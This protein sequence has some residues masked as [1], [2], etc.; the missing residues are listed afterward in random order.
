MVE[1]TDRDVVF[2]DDAVTKYGDDESSRRPSDHNTAVTKTN[3]KKESKFQHKWALIYCTYAV[4]G[5]LLYGYDGTY[6]TGVQAMTAFLQR[7]GQLQADGSYALSA[8]NLSI[9]TSIVYVGELIG[10]M[11]ASLV[12]DRFG[13]KGGLFAAMIAVI[14][15]VVIQ[16]AA[17]GQIGVLIAGRI[18]LG[19]GVGLVSNAVPQYLSEVPNASI[20]GSVVGSWQLILAIG[21][22][23]G[24]CVDQGTKGINSTAAYRIPM[25]LQLIIPV[26]IFGFFPFVPESPRWLASKGRYDEAAKSLIKINKEKLPS[27]D[28]TIELDMLKKDHERELNEKEPSSWKALAT[29]PVERRKLFSVFGILVAQQVTGVQFI[30]SYATIFIED[31]G[32]SD[33]FLWTIII[34]ICEVLGVIVSF[35]LVNRF[36]RRPLLIWTSIVMII[37]L[38]IV[39]GLGTPANPTHGA[40]VGIVVMLM[41]YVFFFNLAWGPL[42]WTVAAEAANGVNRSKIMAV[43]TGGFWIIAFLVTFTL[44]YLYDAGEANLGA[45]VGYV[46]AGGCILSLLFVYFYIGET[47][48]RTLEEINQMFDARLPVMKWKSWNGTHLAAGAHVTKESADLDSLENYPTGQKKVHEEEARME[49]V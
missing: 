6:F 37:S 21:Q 13:R 46:Y 41:I 12:Q 15:G 25:G 20:R 35:F 11:C 40:K 49:H 22:V 14:I 28:E 8:A 17:N 27:Y 26:I 33:A 7:F 2:E 47:L 3:T 31:V 23:I 1:N 44:P 38:I 29:N 18:I 10:S 42:A 45:M 30:F 4:L 5:A 36:G 19:I 32:L 24:A 16:I 34:D 43:G 39:G 48:G 9:M